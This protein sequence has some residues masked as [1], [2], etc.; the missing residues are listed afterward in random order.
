MIDRKQLNRISRWPAERDAARL[1]ENLKLPQVP[2]YPALISLLIWA[3]EESGLMD[4]T[5]AQA[6]PMLEWVL[7]TAMSDAPAALGALLNLEDPATEVTRNLAEAQT[8]REAGQAALALLMDLRA[9]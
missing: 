2:G 5:T 3:V 9:K 6:R 7:L 8:K 1:V 4:K